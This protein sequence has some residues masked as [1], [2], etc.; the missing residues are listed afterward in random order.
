MRIIFP[1]QATKKRDDLQYKCWAY[2][3]TRNDY[4]YHFPPFLKKKK[5]WRPKDSWFLNLH[6]LS[7]YRLPSSLTCSG[8]D[9]QDVTSY[10]SDRANL[11]LFSLGVIQWL[12]V[13][14]LCNKVN[15]L[16]S[17]R[18]HQALGNPELRLRKGC[19][20]SR[21]TKRLSCARELWRIL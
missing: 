15:S 11:S 4:I 19:K 17:F 18:L 12:Q 1:I 20:K 8:L 13:T 6:I 10:F 2:V 7:R 9:P 3:A 16:V 5:K 14:V 21:G